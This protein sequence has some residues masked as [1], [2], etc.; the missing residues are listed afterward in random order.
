MAAL[1][2]SDWPSQN[3][4]DLSRAVLSMIPMAA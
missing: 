1:Q 4:I 2:I 3:H